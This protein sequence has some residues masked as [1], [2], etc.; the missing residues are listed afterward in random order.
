MERAKIFLISYWLFFL[1]GHL[2]MIYLS[3]GLSSYFRGNQYFVISLIIYLP[4]FIT[5]IYA[6]KKISK[7]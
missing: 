4:L 1:L 5:A 7:S 2:F 6:L 3:Q